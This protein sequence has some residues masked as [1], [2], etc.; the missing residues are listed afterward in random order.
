MSEWL[1]TGHFF[2]KGNLFLKDLSLYTALLGGFCCVFLLSRKNS[3]VQTWLP[4]SGLAVCALLYLPGLQKLIN[5]GNASHATLYAFSFI[6]VTTII[7]KKSERFSLT[8]LVFLMYSVVQFVGVIG[9]SRYLLQIDSA[10]GSGVFQYLSPSTSL[11]FLLLT[12]LLFAQSSFN[13]MDLK[14]EQNLAHQNMALALFFLPLGVAGSALLT[15]SVQM[16]I[17]S[18]AGSIPLMLGTSTFLGSF[19]LYLFG[20]YAGRKEKEVTT[21]LREQA[22]ELES[23]H[24]DKIKAAEAIASE[25]SRFSSVLAHEIR[26]PLSTVLGLVEVLRNKHSEDLKSIGCDK[27]FRQIETSAKLLREMINSVLD[28]TK[29][30]AGKLSL[31][32]Q[33]HSIPLLLEELAFLY[34]STVQDKA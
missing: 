21:K 33:P 15:N 31:N 23:L 14:S 9:V 25:Q 11:M 28:Y 3:K 32:P 19:F 22:Q 13:V 24:A 1:F 8:A 6:F 10:S 34:A 18:S 30:K 20:S 17:D 2:L 5:L 12:P 16:M 4:F 26:T 7:N 29:I 27:K